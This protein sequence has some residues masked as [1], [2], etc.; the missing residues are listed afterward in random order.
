MTYHDSFV[1][2]ISESLERDVPEELLPLT[3]TRQAA[4]HAGWE[5]DHLGDPAWS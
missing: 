3:I 4:F 5:A 2:A 1:S